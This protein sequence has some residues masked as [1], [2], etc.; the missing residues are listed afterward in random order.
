G[1]AM[2]WF[3]RALKHS[4]PDDAAMRRVILTNLNATQHHL[5]RRERVFKHEGRL[6]PPAF[7]PDGK[8]LLTTAASRLGVI[9]HPDSATVGAEN[10]LTGGRVV[11]SGFSAD[12]EALVATYQR[13][14]L[15]VHRL[16][17]K[18]DSATGP[19]LVIAHSEEIAKASF[20]PQGRLLAVAPPADR[21]A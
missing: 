20:D 5:L 17:A 6:T 14:S 16:P 11:A 10:P 19:P 1:A 8:R 15:L 18:A 7:S 4:P 9:W 13:G 2:L 12:G 21:S 3:A